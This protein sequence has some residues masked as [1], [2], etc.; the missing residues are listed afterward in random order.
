VFS[1][2]LAAPALA[3]PFYVWDFGAP[4]VGLEN[5]ALGTNTLTIGSVPSSGKTVTVSGFDKISPSFP[6]RNLYYKNT[7]SDEH[8]LGFVNTS[9]NELTLNSAGVAANFM[10]ID[11]VN[12]YHSLIVGMI[13]MQ[14]VTNGEKFDVYGANATTNFANLLV[15]GSN[16][17]NVWL[18][19][20]SW[21]TYQYYLVTVH[22]NNN[23]NNNNNHNNNND[24]NDNN[25]DNVLL[26]AVGASPVP[27]PGSLMLLGTG[28]VGLA[29]IARRRRV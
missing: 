4:T 17:D 27:E 6:G 1:L 24:N 28:L 10:A 25:A 8:G 20:P 22:P 19:L 9:D 5:T 18:T 16:A 11:V 7:G 3:A 21:G 12:I 15:N 2:F 29:R 26:D 14:S 13:R 23:S